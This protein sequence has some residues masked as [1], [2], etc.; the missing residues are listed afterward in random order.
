V[1]NIGLRWRLSDPHEVRDGQQLAA[2]SSLDLF[3]RSRNHGTCTYTRAS[4]AS[5]VE[6]EPGRVVPLKG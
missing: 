1:K 6:A 3:V 2:S 5:G 4:A